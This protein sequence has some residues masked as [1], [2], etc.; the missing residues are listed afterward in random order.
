MPAVTYYQAMDTM[1]EFEQDILDL[2]EETRWEAPS[3]KKIGWYGLACAIVSC[4]VEEWCW[5]IE[6]ELMRRIEDR[7]CEDGDD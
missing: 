4:A 2:L 5:Q 7:K 3:V 1:H 6:D